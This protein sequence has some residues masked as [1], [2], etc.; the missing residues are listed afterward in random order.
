MENFKPDKP[1]AEIVED[2]FQRGEFAKRVATIANKAFNS[3][4]LVI[5]IYGKWGEGKTSV[6]KLIQNELSENVVSIHFN[7]WY[8][9]DENEL[10]INFLKEISNKLGKKLSSN[11]KIVLQAIAD[12]GESVTSFISAL[13]PS[14]LINLSA[15][16]GKQISKKFSS[17]TLEKQKHR[18]NEFII[19]ANT[20]FVVFIDDIDRLNIK[21][22][23]TVFRLIKLLGDFPRF[24]YVLAFDD[25]L[26]AR[27]LGHQFGEGKTVDGYEY[28]EKIVQ[29]P[30]KLPTPYASELRKFTLKH[31][32]AA[33]ESISIQLNDEQIKR[34]L[35]NFDQAFVPAIKNPRVA[36]RLSNAIAFSVPLIKGEVNLSDFLILECIK[37]FFPELY[38]FIKDNRDL[39]TSHYDSYRM[40]YTDSNESYK[41]KS[42]TSINE[43]LQK[44]PEY[45]EGRIKTLLCDLFPQL[46]SLFGNISYPDSTKI[47]WHQQQRICSAAYFD[48]YFSYVILKGEISDTYFKQLFSEVTTHSYQHTAD[49]IRKE[50][51]KLSLTDFLFKLKI[52]ADLFTKAECKPL[53][54]ALSIIGEMIP[55]EK[56]LVIF[57]PISDLSYVIK[58]LVAKIDL[59]E[60]LPLAEQVIE[61]ADTYRYTL[62]ICSSFLY[63][64]KDYSEEPLFTDEQKKV[65]ANGVI[66]KF[67]TILETQHIGRFTEEE[68]YRTLSLYKYINSFAFPKQLFYKEID[69]NNRFSLTVLR[70]FSPTVISSDRDTPYKTILKDEDYDFMQL[71]IDIDYLYQQIMQAFGSPPLEDKRF[72]DR[73]PL[74][75]TQ[76]IGLFQK[77]YRKKKGLET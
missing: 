61:I 3:T 33:L 26:V 74:S 4:S 9:K 59:N 6:L 16:L 66:R 60:K 72:D 7:P 2:E 46:N 43:Q 75:N 8:F 65:V 31:V 53:A 54:L 18:V 22:I 77:W 68:I 15:S 25:E 70:F 34:F 17:D 76:L 41:K 24:T 5:G 40:S 73:E 44:N 38:D 71:F 69:Q 57:Q 50:L 10:L 29:V 32:D 56:G 12:Y 64:P 47:E 14:P 52:K 63:T 55:I 35:D 48:R 37:I 20:L 67:E 51:P 49:A 19:Q 58:K 1:I 62:E 11:P 23:Q 13:T 27:S 45:L 30:I 36:I 28:L 39:F 42:L 21:E